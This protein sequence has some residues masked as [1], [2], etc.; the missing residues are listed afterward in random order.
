MGLV[1]VAKG[2]AP[3][4]TVFCAV[5]MGQVEEEH[6]ALRLVE[7]PWLVVQ[8]LAVEPLWALALVYWLAVD[9][10]VVLWA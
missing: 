5:A 2:Y 7:S 10:L 3:D 4:Y 8:Q 9:W 1:E 6:L